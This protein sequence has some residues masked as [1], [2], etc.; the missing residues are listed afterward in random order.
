MSYYKGTTTC[1]NS[2]GYMSYYKGTTTCP[3]SG[4]NM[5]KYYEAV[6][7]VQGLVAFSNQYLVIDTVLVH[8]ASLLWVYIFSLQL[9]I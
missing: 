3:N 8:V 4:G 7:F 6:A 1:P 5:S 9:D 2:G